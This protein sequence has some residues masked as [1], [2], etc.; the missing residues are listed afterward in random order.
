MGEG[1]EMYLYLQEMQPQD[2][3]S[4]QDSIA[5]PPGAVFDAPPPAPVTPWDRDAALAPLDTYVLVPTLL[6]PPLRRAAGMRYLAPLWALPSWAVQHN[7][8]DATT[9]APY[10]SRC[11]C[12]GDDV[13]VGEQILLARGDVF[14][15]RCPGGTWDGRQRRGFIPSTF[16]KGGLMPLRHPVAE[17]NNWG[18]ATRVPGVW[19]GARG[20]LL[21]TF[22]CRWSCYCACCREPIA[23]GDPILWRSNSACR[24]CAIRYGLGGARGPR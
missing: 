21:K 13:H 10:E 11:R 14:C 3:F 8:K 12:C 9:P 16:V 19:T 15:T 17:P 22:T 2:E 4:T 7:G 6:A 18:Q 23:V 20:D 5:L 24:S 1:Y